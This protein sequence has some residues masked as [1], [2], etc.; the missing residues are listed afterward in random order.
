MEVRTVI[1][2]FPR[3]GEKRELKKAL[4]GYWNNNI[5]TADLNSVSYRLREKQWRDQKERGIDLISCNDFSWYDSM[6]DTAVMLNT[7]PERFRT[8]TDKIELYFSM[9][10]GTGD[11]HAME[12]TK[13]FN[14]NYHYIVP[15]LDDGIK[16]VL[17]P[18]K[19]ISEFNE[20]KNQGVTPKIN[21][22]GPL[23]FLGL[24]KCKEGGDCYKYSERVVPV[25]RE[26]IEE[27]SSLDETVYLQIDEPV[28]ARDPSELQL[29][30]LKKTYD[31]LAGLRNN[32]RIIVTTYFEHSNEATAVLI[33]T[34]VWGIGLDFVHGAD[35][36][37]FIKNFNG[38]KLVAGVVD[39]R[40]VWVNNLQKTLG[41][42]DGLASIIPK[43]DII[44]GTSCSLLHVPYSAQFESENIKTDR[45]FSFAIEKVNEVA[46]L[47]RLFH[48]SV[49]SEEDKSILMENSSIVTGSITVN[50]GRSMSKGR[51]GKKSERADEY[52]ERNILQKEYLKL[53]ALPTTTIG[54]FPQ[55]D[56]IR[57]L[58]SEYK[59]GKITVEKYECG[60]RK[61]IDECISF[62]EEIGLDVLVHG[63]AERNDMVEYFGEMLD[64]FHFTDNGW[65]QSYGSRCVKPPVIVSD[66]LRPSPMTIRWITYA[67]SRTD[68][69]VKGML[70]GPVTI[71]QWSFTREDI[72]RHEVAEQIALALCGEIS[73]L[74]D[75][76]IKIIQVDEPAFKEAYPLRKNKVREYEEWA[77]K[78]FKLAVSAAN[79]QTQIHTHMCYSE[80]NEIIQTIEAM[81]ADVFSIETAR[82]GNELL[83][84][85]KETGYS[86]EIGPGIYDIHSPRIPTVDEFVKQIRSIL[87]VLPL[88]Q[89]WINPDCGLKTRNWDEVKPSLK[90]MIEAVRIVRAS[91]DVAG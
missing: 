71:M 17:N 36:L 27:I 19:I 20:A 84:I 86:H 81:D 73:D 10:R 4:E 5:S 63:E 82:S 74:Q 60:I 68:R 31:E 22:I 79:K 8:I 6:L 53:P 87:E 32:V 33:G 44:I 26:L 58:R 46:L 52:G 39:G 25:Y 48:E 9:A 14:T 7:V 40:N 91:F 89:V 30:L 35:N 21:I 37:K 29:S 11:S 59:N 78:N 72:P 15:E 85:F 45:L 64:G 70:T 61:F 42:L 50:S 38:K 43:D 47:S 80:F 16:F 1:A 24:S 23:T 3:I 62:Q 88:R 75:A 67:Q 55:T 56:G 65:V 28:F 13:W 77:V 49:I 12:M 83:K 90:N 57:K 69:I 76:G 51:V 66:V 18:E 34:P 41:F 2:G 54:S